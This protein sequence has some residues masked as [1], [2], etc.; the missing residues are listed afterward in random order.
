[1]RVGSLALLENRKGKATGG[2]FGFLKSVHGIVGEYGIK[3]CFVVF[4]GGISK[5]RRN[6]LPEYRGARQRQPGDPFYVEPDDDKKEYDRKFDSQRRMLQFVL[7]KMGVRALRIE[8]WE[9]DDLAYLL[10]RRIEQDGGAIN[11]ISDDK[12]WLQ[13]VTDKRGFTVNTIRPI[14]EQFVTY[15]NFEEEV[16]C[17]QDQFL[18]RRAII[19]ETGSDN[20]PGIPGVGEKTAAQI[21]EEGAPACRFPFDEIFNFC[22]EHKQKRVRKIS[23]N[24]DILWRNYEVINLSYELPTLDVNRQVDA[25]VRSAVGVDLISVKRFFTEL[26]LFSVLKELHTWMVPF[27][28]LS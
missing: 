6:L 11:L 25:C 14:G 24:I 20:I 9:A 28:K 16:G 2:F 22:S 13:M 15:D 1:M 7:A 12:D 10:V 21:F 27:Q 18:I 19:G 5:R 3:K 4:D 8:G 26:D 23:D 17:P